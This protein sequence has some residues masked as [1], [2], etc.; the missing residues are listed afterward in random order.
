MADTTIESI[1]RENLT[2]IQITRYAFDK[3][4]Y[5]SKRM[6][7]YCKPLSK[8]TYEL[9]FYLIG[10]NETEKAMV[11]DDIFIAH[12][13]NVSSES[14]SFS[15]SGDLKSYPAIYNAGKNI[16][17]WGHSHGDFGIFFSRKDWEA[18]N[19]LLFTTNARLQKSSSNR[20]K[21]E[22]VDHDGKKCIKIGG[23]HEYT[24]LTS[25]EHDISEF[26]IS[27]A[28]I[29]DIDLRYMYAMVFNANMTDPYTLLGYRIGKE[30]HYLEHIGAKIIEERGGKLD[31]KAIDGE[32]EERVV[33]LRKLKPKLDEKLNE[34]YNRIMGS[35]KS[36]A[37][38]VKNNF[39]DEQGEHS[40]ENIAKVVETF[41][42]IPREIE[43]IS[44]FWPNG[45]YG[46]AQDNL[47]RTYE[48]LKKIVRKNR[49]QLDFMLNEADMD[50]RASMTKKNM[51]MKRSLKRLIDI[52]SL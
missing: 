2:P 13:Q 50:P 40:Y 39:E 16:I 6:R 45:N 15:E 4:N 5:V 19:G 17:G 32:L 52:C 7:D 3:A 27:A 46:K 8:P 11:I 51:E 43:E 24:L 47:N 26:D 18:M 49:G 36:V 34:E 21:P 38:N 28:D 22:I 30:N 29:Q 41:E 1:V 23:D 25:A 44:R 12:D 42:T 37:K 9:T 14:C 35:M 20:Y 31:R 48:R 33:Q 10:E